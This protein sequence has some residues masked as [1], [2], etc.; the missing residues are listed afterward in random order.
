MT[1]TTSSAVPDDLLQYQNHCERADQLVQQTI[2]PLLDSLDAYRRAMSA[3][4]LG[5]DAVGTA[6]PA[7]ESLLST[8][9]QAAAELDAFVGSVGNDF[10]YADNLQALE[11]GGSM[12]GFDARKGLVT[13]SD[14]S[15]DQITSWLATFKMPSRRG[16]AANG[17]PGFD[18]DPPA[19]AVLSNRIYWNFAGG[20]TYVS[21]PN[22]CGEWQ[23]VSDSSAP[24][25]LAGF[26]E[27][28]PTRGSAPFMTWP[29][30]DNPGWIVALDTSSGAKFEIDPQ[31]FVWTRGSDGQLVRDQSAGDGLGW[32]LAPPDKPNE[33]PLDFLWNNIN[34]ISA[35]WYDGLK[36]IPIP[37]P[38]P[39]PV[40]IGGGF[41]DG[42]GDDDI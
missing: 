25:Y 35:D 20:W 23:Q 9:P 39:P 10:V 38:P 11:S 27:N 36:S 3:A 24:L 29:D 26:D 22:A 33:P 12:P 19:A 40:P 37:P 15:L 21:G 30:M 8:W 4:G 42:D 5:G 16:Q 6:L 32:R 14:A 28:G 13:V 1:D 2:R 17:P 18:I 34:E 7:L 31:G 41:G